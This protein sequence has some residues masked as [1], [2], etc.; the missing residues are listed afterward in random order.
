MTTFANDSPPRLVMKQLKL[1][2]EL[3][4]F[5]EPE[6][7][8]C[9]RCMD[10][11]ANEPLVARLRRVGDGALLVREVC[12]APSCVDTQVLGH[13]CRRHARQRDARGGSAWPVRACNAC[14][15]GAL[16]VYRKDEEM[17]FIMRSDV[18]VSGGFSGFEVR[19]KPPV[20]GVEEQDPRRGKSSGRRLSVWGSR[21]RRK[22]HKQGHKELL[23]AREWSMGNIEFT[24]L[25]LWKDKPQPLAPRRSVVAA[26]SGSKLP[27]L[28]VYPDP[29]AVFCVVKGCQ[30]FAK[31]E[32][33]CRFHSDSPL[34][35]M[36][37]GP[38]PPPPPPA[39]P[40]APAAPAASSA[41]T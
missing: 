3:R 11:E 16:E 41:A 18:D 9:A 21:P 33:R 30:R 40:A 15:T 23:R 22:V 10:E 38:P 13:F 27:G 6:L 37:L 39:V 4:R 17:W 31:T 29:T 28:A 32:D 1:E 25:M 24:K 36:F 12:A 26:T 5:L 7:A 35:S 14:R 2:L 20:G 34:A 19:H 8:I